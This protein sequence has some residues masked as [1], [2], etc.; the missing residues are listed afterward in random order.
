MAGSATTASSTY[1]AEE[2]IAK[3]DDHKWMADYYFKLSV[4]ANLM[5]ADLR[6]R[7]RKQ[8]WSEWGDS[9]EDLL[10]ELSTVALVLSNI[11][12]KKGK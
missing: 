5:A 8:G 10:E 12:A 11:E 4:R 9:E 3:A 6:S 1:T 2:F 7:K